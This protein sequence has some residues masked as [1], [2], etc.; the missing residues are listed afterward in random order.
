MGARQ[1]TMN[2]ESNPANLVPS[3]LS[4]DELDT[5]I[6]EALNIDGRMSVTE[7]SWSRWGR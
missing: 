6:I 3:D 5:K 4:L 2:D 7:K 1:T